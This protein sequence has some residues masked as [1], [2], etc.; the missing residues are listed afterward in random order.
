MVIE[1]I[2]L[3]T[4]LAC[5]AVKWISTASLKDRHSKLVEANEELGKE[6]ARYKALVSDVNMADHK[7]QKLQR[8]IRATQHRIGKLSKAQAA[9]QQEMSKSAALD[10]EKLRLAEEV[11]KKLEG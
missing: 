4:M 5:V 1:I 10:A 2:L 9:L 11:R 3:G 6:K 8:K 7:I